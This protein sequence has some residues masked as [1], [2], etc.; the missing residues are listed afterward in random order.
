MI[1]LV[2]PENLQAELARTAFP[3]SELNNK[4]RTWKKKSQLKVIE[5]S[6]MLVQVQDEEQNIVDS[7]SEDME[8]DEE[9]GD[10]EPPVDGLD[11]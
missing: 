7:D 9:D 2:K 8:G 6:N 11:I 10:I 3:Y 4:M 5:P 1:V